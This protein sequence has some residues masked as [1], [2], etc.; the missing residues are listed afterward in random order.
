MRENWGLYAG[1]DVCAYLYT[2]AFVNSVRVCMYVCV[3]AFMSLHFPLP[4]AT[5]SPASSPSLPP[6]PFS[7]LPYPASPSYSPLPYSHPPL[8]ST[9][10]SP[11]PLLTPSPSS[12]AVWKK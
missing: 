10:L 6:T 1:A 11:P 3:H 5:P 9:F 8:P 4:L 7:F 2:R 12:I